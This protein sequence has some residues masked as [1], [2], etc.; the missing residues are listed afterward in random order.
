[1]AMSDSVDIEAVKALD[2]IGLVRVRLL[3][4]SDLPCKGGLRSLI[5]QDRPDPYAK[6][7]LGSQIQVT[8]VV[9]NCQDPEWADDERQVPFEVLFILTSEVTVASIFQL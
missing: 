1:M 9:K 5:G 3:S 6:L 4:S 7:M 8:S 2:P